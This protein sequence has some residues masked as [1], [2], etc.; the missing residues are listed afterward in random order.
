M[1][2]DKYLKLTRLIKRRT[3]AKELIERGGFLINDKEAKPSS[4]VKIDDILE[5]NLGRH[6]L[7]VKVLDIKEYAKKEDSTKLYE[8]LK[9]EIK[10][11]EQK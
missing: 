5:I 8:I 2:F 3:I 6:Y 9:D 4:E 11:T 10:E 7:K 1:R